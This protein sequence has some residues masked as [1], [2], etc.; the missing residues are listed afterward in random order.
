[1]KKENIIFSGV[2]DVASEYWTWLK[3]T[4][5]Y[6]TAIVYYGKDDLIWEKI[7]AVATYSWRHSGQIFPSLVRHFNELDYNN[8][9]IIDNDLIALPS[10]I[11]HSFNILSSSN[12]HALGWSQDPSG[13]NTWAELVCRKTEHVY[14]TN[15]IESGMIFLK[16]ELLKNVIDFV[17][18]KCQKI[19]ELVCGWDIV[20]S[21]VAFENNKQP[22][23]FLDFYSYRNPHPYEKGINDRE[24]LISMPIGDQLVGITKLCASNN[25]Y[26]L[27]D[28]CFGQAE[29]R[30]NIVL[31][32]DQS[33]KLDA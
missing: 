2:G 1:M 24:I 27:P 28:I 20:L 18:E 30:I 7:Q 19:D 10:Q 26:F 5:E 3:Q 17:N 32:K 33:L 13:Q 14:E 6:D 4:K 21:N 23:L 12:N 29:Q 16:K 9:L 22:F 15:F 31:A 8:F 11:S 25:F